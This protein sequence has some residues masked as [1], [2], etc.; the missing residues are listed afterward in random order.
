MQTQCL[1]LHKVHDIAG[2]QTRKPDAPVTKAIF[3]KLPYERHVIDDRCF[4]QGAR[5]MQILNVSLCTGLNRGQP[6]RRH[7]LRR[8]QP[9][10]IE[11][12]NEMPERSTV[13]RTRSHVPRTIT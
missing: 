12:I 8:N 13:S 1:T 7:S 9:L 11:K 5:L 2:T 10:T 4:G 3:E 6:T